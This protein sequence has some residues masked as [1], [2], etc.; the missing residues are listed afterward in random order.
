MARKKIKPIIH[1]PFTEYISS[2]RHAN[3]ITMTEL[4]ESIGVTPSYISLLEAGERQP[5]REIVLK[6]GAVFFAK[7]DTDSLDELLLLA[8]LSP[9][10][11]A[12]ADQSQKL[13]TYYEKQQ[14]DKPD[15]CLYSPMIRALI[16]HEHT[17]IAEDKIYAGMKI[18]HQTHQLQAL[19]ASLQLNLDNFEAAASSQDSAILLYQNNPGSPN[20]H[21]LADLYTNQGFIYFRWGQA[22]FEDYLQSSSEAENNDSSLL[23]ESQKKLAQANDFHIQAIEITPLELNAQIH[24]AQ[25]LF[26][27]A[28]VDDG[29]NSPLYTDSIGAFTQII[30]SEEFN[31]LEQS[32]IRDTS[33]YLAYAYSKSKDFVEARKLIGILQASY[34]D[35]W[36]IYY[37]KACHY[38]LQAHLDSNSDTE[39]YLDLSLIALEKAL[40]FKHSYS[41]VQKQAKKDPDLQNLR[42]SRPEQFKQLLQNPQNLSS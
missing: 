12:R 4:S 33:I 30:C 40:N 27:Q 17:K 2:L 42:L 39:K 23:K 16:A 22:I 14:K 18:F 24:Y 3:G 32:V 1:T 29:Q 8:G 15:F 28:N 35:Y 19:M 36:W 11:F 6:I 26:M 10:R 5:S 34:Q 37:I 41:K 31:N 13:L 9:T 38:A 20:P 25:T 21:E 7:E